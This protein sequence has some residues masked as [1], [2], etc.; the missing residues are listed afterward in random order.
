LLL[1]DSEG[2]AADGEGDNG[3]EEE[4]AEFSNMLADAILKRPE[5]IR[6]GSFKSA[7]KDGSRGK[8]PNGTINGNV[9][10]I[11]IKK[12]ETRLGESGD[13]NGEVGD[14]E[15]EQEQERDEEP[16]E[17]GDGDGWIRDPSPFKPSRPEPRRVVSGVSSGIGADDEGS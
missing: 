7:R 4:Q 5:S 16:D 9:M 17:D 8:T 12:E 15:P 3:E 14:Q 13:I 6:D 1:G 11:I 2:D 10:E